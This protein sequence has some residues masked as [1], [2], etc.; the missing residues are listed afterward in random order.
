MRQ[1]RFLLSFALLLLAAE[2]DAQF[3]FSFQGAGS[4]NHPGFFSGYRRGYNAAN[5]ST[6]DK[7]LGIPMFAYGYSY[8]AGYR[9][10]HLSASVGRT[11]LETQTSAKFTNGTKRIIQYDYNFTV[12]E[13]GYF[14]YSE[15][16]EYT[17]EIGLLHSQSGAYSY[18][19]Y[20]DGTKDAFSGVSGMMS[21]V[22]LGATAR[23]NFLRRIT[24]VIW[25]DFMCQGFYLKNHPELSPKFLYNTEQATLD[26]IGVTLSAGLTFRLGKH[27]D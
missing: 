26:F 19:Q 16:A 11:H 3:V 13:A 18:V 1:I 5:A 7:K 6:L 25:F 10:L 9:V 27:Y 12:V 2:V 8:N 15:N 17:I 20:P 24:D 23:V 22:N 4:V 21:W 14:G